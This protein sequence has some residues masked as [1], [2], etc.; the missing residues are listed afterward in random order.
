M[1]RQSNI[2]DYIDDVKQYAKLQSNVAEDGITSEIA[3]HFDFNFEGGVQ[4][5]IEIPKFPS[6][7]EIG[8][9]VGSSGSGKSTILKQS[10]GN[11][12]T[13]EWDMNKSIASHFSDYKEASEKFGAVGLNSIPTWLKPYNVLSNGEKFRADMSRRLKNGAVIDE[14]TSVVNRECAISCSV[15]IQKYIRKQKLHNIVFCSCHDDIIPFLKPT[16]VYNTDTHSF[17]ERGCVRQPKIS[18]G[19]HYCSTKAWDIFKRF[20]YLSGDLNKS[21]NCYLATMKDIPIGFI[22][23]LALPSG[24]LHHAFREHRV[25]ILPDYQGMGIGNKLSETIGQAYVNAGCRY[26][27]KTSNPRMG[28]HRDKSS[29]WKATAH[30]HSDRKEY[31]NKDGSMKTSKYSMSAERLKFHSQ[32]VCYCHEYIGDGNTYPFTYNDPICDK[33]NEVQM[34]IFD[35]I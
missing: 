32:R 16:W 8:V 18:I 4:E 2:F 34:N 21:A 35:F 30:N 26:F 24:S 10:F 3:K 29:L 5:I 6:E 7:F 28:E 13:I 22:A 14:F 31:K 33:D 11:E 12:E 25:V 15:S 17:T 1:E 20:H 23:I 19:L 9:I 27:A